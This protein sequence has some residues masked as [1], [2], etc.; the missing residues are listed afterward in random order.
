LHE[1]VMPDYGVIRTEEDQGDRDKCAPLQI[2]LLFGTGFEVF[3]IQC[4][5]AYIS[6]KLLI[7]HNIFC[8]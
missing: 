5:N 8:L 2:L 3:T 4:T 1:P 6:K 7:L